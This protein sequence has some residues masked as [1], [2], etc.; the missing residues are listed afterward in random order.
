MKGLE[1]GKEIEIGREY[2]I[3]DLWD[4]NGG[5]FELTE[6]IESGCVSPDEETVVAF[7]VILEAGT[8]SIVEVTDI[9]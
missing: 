8:E 1:T 7:K 5:V 2:T 3:L 6:I 4:G 9:Y